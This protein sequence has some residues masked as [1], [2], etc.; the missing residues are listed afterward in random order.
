MGVHP[1]AQNTIEYFD[2]T[3]LYNSGIKINV[4]KKKI[5]IAIHVSLDAHEYIRLTYYIV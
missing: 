5:Q 4:S 2:V 3:V 1:T